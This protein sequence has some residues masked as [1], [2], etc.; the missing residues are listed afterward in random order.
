MKTLII[1]LDGLELNY[2]L[3]WNLK[4][5]LQKNYG[6]HDVSMIERI[7]TPLIWSAFLT[8]Q[9]PQEIGY[10]MEYIEKQRIN[11]YPS[12]L[13]TF[14]LLRKRFLPK[15]NLNLRRLAMKLGIYDMKKTNMPTN[16]RKQTFVSKLRDEGYNVYIEEFPSYNEFEKEL[17]A[18]IDPGLYLRRSF[19]ERFR[20]VKESWDFTIKRWIRVLHVIPTHDLILFYTNFPDSAHHVLFKE[21]ELIFVKDFYL[22]LENLPFLKDLKNIV[23]L[24]VSDHGFIHNEHTHSNYGFW[25]SNINL[26][27]EPKTVFDFHDLIIKL[28]RTPKIKQPFQDS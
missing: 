16:I 1:C 7:Y 13:R 11:A 14:A 28:V 17:F 12:I 23:K 15:K 25:S 21:E 3:K 5:L 18:R 24:I 27:Y 4:G 22:K 10:T 9:N 20:R 26:P 19:D 8:G 6:T 2:V